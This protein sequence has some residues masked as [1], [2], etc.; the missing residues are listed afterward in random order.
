MTCATV[1]ALRVGG[2]ALRATEVALYLN[3]LRSCLPLATAGK[4]TLAAVALSA[5]SV[6]VTVA[7]WVLVLAV[8]GVPL[9][10]PLAALMVSPGGRSAAA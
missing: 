2:V 10:A 9:M 6:A 3:P 8:S 1:G 7:P 5:L 4:V